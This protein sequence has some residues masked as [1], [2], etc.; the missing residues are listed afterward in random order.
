[1]TADAGYAELHRELRTLAR[2][3]LA[4]TPDPDW[5]LLASTGLLGLEVP[6]E[7]GGAGAS[8]AEVAVVLH[9]LG[10]VASAAP[11]LGSVVLAVAALRE[12][13]AADLCAAV[14]SGE[15]RLAIALPTGDDDSFAFTLA[16]GKVT[17]EATYVPDAVDADDVLVVTEQGLALV[18][19]TRVEQP[20]LDATRRLCRVH[21]DGAEP[22]QVW[23]LPAGAD[24]RL[25]DRGAVAVAADS[26]GAAE[27][28]LEA[29]VAYAK[30][31]HQ[32]GQPIGSF[33]AVKHACADM[34]VSIAVARSLVSDA[35]AAVA[36][37]RADSWVAAALA[38]SNVAE[39]GVRVVGKAM[40][41][42]GGIGFTWEGDVHRYLKRV[43]LNRTLF[44]SPHYHRRRVATRYVAA[45]V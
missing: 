35:V 39:A 15:R 28:M 45:H 11:Y 40:Q 10:R 20:V 33:Q 43:A 34:L 18:A 14:A 13:G 22:A 26:L 38:K 30:L 9:E 19:A 5:P 4:R 21:V 41:L 12:A 37:D 6:D 7:A 42:H 27:A 2:D 24:A 29:T 25:R 44:G 8:F 3:L 31:R 1:M 16:A 36:A 23:A 32:F 17:G